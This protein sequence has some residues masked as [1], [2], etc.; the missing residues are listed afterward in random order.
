MEGRCKSGTLRRKLKR[1]RRA[2]RRAQTP[3]GAITPLIT[4]SVSRCSVQQDEHAPARLPLPVHGHDLHHLSAQGWLWLQGERGAAGTASHTDSR[5]S[6]RLVSVMMKSGFH[7]VVFFF[8]RFFSLHL[9]EQEGEQRGVE[10]GF[11]GRAGP[12]LQPEYPLR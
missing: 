2:R 3:G 12:F 8:V 1:V 7:F 11:R 5:A 9:V 4:P 6:S 10:L